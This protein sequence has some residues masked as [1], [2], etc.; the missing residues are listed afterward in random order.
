MDE[1]I[2]QGT[3]TQQSY[4][5]TD[6]R[7]TKQNKT[8][9]ERKTRT[10]ISI[11][12]G[13]LKDNNFGIESKSI[14]RED[15]RKDKKKDRHKI[16]E[17]SLQDNRFKERRYTVKQICKMLKITRQAY[18]KNRYRRAEESFE[19]E[20]IV[21]M[22]NNIRHKLPRLGGRKLYYLL[23]EDLRKLPSNLGRDKFFEI[24]RSNG[25]LVK[26]TKQY[27][28]TT[29]SHHRFRIYSNLVKG[30][31]VKE[32]NQI[33]VSDITYLRLEDG[34]CYLF[35]TTDVYSRK[36]VGYHLSMSLSTEG[37]IS[38]MEMA[39]KNL[40]KPE[41]L[42]HHSDRGFQ[43]CCR[44]Y[45]GLLQKNRIRISMGESGNPYENAIA[46]RVNG[47]LKSEFYLN[48]NFMNYQDA[49]RATKEAIN[50]YNNLRPHMSIGYLTPEQK[51]AA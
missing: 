25:L 51:Y 23:K 1:E 41:E 28:R 46:E 4:P 17:Y 30:M 11:S 40:A 22:V 19:E 9:R 32:P 44:Q 10:G 13:A 42:I 39:L 49:S 34:F 50:I 31:S 15:R 21:E 3:F 24:L 29:N 6:E 33:F 38:A 7:R 12:S 37:A 35:L 14:G 18:Y 45:V 2:R 20:I 36:I 8:I 48:S 26:P 47:I 16:I 27:T 5:H 43:Y